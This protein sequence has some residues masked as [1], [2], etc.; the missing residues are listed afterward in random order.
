MRNPIVERYAIA[1]LTG[2]I[3]AAPL[4]AVSF[5]AGANM[6]AARS[7]HTATLLSDGRI[8][9]TGGGA[10]V[11]SATAEVYDP[12]A[13]TTTTV[14]P[15]AVARVRHTATLLADGRVLIAG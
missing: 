10:G 12:V 3:M 5:T 14:G 7:H 15:M 6:K 8:L 9:I 4:A 13:G 11:A 2:F 1:L